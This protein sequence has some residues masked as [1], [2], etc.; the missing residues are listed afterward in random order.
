M[1]L[2]IFFESMD[3]ITSKL[4]AR[5]SVDVIFLGFLKVP[6]LRLLKK[7]RGYREDDKLMDWFSSFLKSRKQRVV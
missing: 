4:D 5:E 6:H 2:K 3:Y 1:L 7:F